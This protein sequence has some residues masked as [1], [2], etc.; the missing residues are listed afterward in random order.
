MSTSS[1]LGSSISELNSEALTCMPLFDK[2]K[3]FSDSPSATI[4]FLI[5]TLSFKNE[6]LSCS[7]ATFNLISFKNSTVSNFVLN[8]LKFCEGTES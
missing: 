3:L 5:F 8:A 7:T 4:F 6:K 1:V 2:S